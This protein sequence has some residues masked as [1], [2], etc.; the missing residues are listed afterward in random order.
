MTTI[1]QIIPTLDSGG[2]ERTTLE[3]ARAIVAEGGKALVAT[4]GGRLTDEVERAGGRVV[5]LPVD[6]KNPLTMTRN[7]RR[8]AQVIRDEKVDLVDVRSRAPAWSA[9][10]ATRRTGTP[11]VAT[12]HGAYSAKSPL[13]RLYN[14]GM[15]RADLV[16]ANSEYTAAAI[17][18][19]YDMRGRR[20]VVIPRGADVAA[21][22]PAKIERARAEA[23]ARRWNV[24]MVNDRRLR[25]LLP[26]RLTFWKGHIVTLDALA[27][28]VSRQGSR[29]RENLQ[30]FFAGDEG[31]KDGGSAALQREIDRRGV[32]TMVRIVGHCA[33]MP[34][35]YALA[36]IVLCP[37]TLPEAFGRIA[38]EA[39]AMEKIAIGADHGAQRETIVD[40]ETG[41]LAPPGDAEGLADAI[42][43]AAS[44]SGTERAGM[45]RAARRRVMALY[46]SQ[47][48]C[49]AT[50]AAY[51]TLIK[52]QASVVEGRV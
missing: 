21:F 27:A 33:D 5:L 38:V 52:K 28:L 40:G 18:A 16:I 42:D 8:L 4:R 2:A 31:R 50:L 46:S 25:L 17:R 15:V 3:V 23:L 19:Q 30:V 35:A 44:L 34:A 24:D 10:M 29:H 37:S 12:Y 11:L 41:F 47:S 36:D 51:R 7:A 43:A 20:L 49:D 9:L 48:M 32:G 26:A 14:S 45:G 22:D 13:K 39:A 6:S 1:L